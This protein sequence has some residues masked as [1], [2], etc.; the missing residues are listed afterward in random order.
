MKTPLPSQVRKAAEC[1]CPADHDRIDTTDAGLVILARKWAELHVKPKTRDQMD[2][3]LTGLSDADARR[4]I[5]CGQRIAAG[6]T[7]KIVRD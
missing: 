1:P 6:L 4:V 5:L 3:V 7:P 2:D